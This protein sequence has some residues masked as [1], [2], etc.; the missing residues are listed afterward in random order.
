MVT[1][2]VSWLLSRTLLQGVP[3]SFTLELPLSQTAN[4]ENHCT[5][6]FRPYLVCPAPRHLRSC[7]AGGLTWILANIHVGG[8][9]LLAHA[10][11]SLNPS[12]N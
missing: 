11:T 4:R 10:A 6:Y 12:V 9:S 8:T 5:F 3:S 2:L 1:L 7:P